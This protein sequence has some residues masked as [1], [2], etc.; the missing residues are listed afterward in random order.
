MMPL[1][2]QMFKYIQLDVCDK[3]DSSLYYTYNEKFPNVPTE[4]IFHRI[5]ESKPNDEK[6]NLE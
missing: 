6:L 5:A 2:N 1:S 4:C 3:V